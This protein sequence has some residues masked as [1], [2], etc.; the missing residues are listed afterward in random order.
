MPVLAMNWRA[1][2]LAETMRHD[3]KR[4]YLQSNTDGLLGLVT[5]GARLKAPICDCRTYTTGYTYAAERWCYRN[6]MV[7]G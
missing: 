1:E 5:N 7:S 3:T 2:S 4:R 6:R